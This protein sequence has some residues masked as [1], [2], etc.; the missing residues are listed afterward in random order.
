VSK[1]PVSKKPVE[2]TA[3]NLPSKRELTNAIMS[4]EQKVNMMYNSMAT[5]NRNLIFVLDELTEE[6]P[7]VSETD[8]SQEYLSVHVNHMFNNTYYDDKEENFVRLTPI[9]D[10]WTH[11]EDKGTY[12][13]DKEGEKTYIIDAKDELAAM[14]ALREK[15]RAAVTFEPTFSLKVVEGTSGE[16]LP[17]TEVI[18]IMEK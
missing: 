8:Y 15:L 9:V 14:K 18:E 16:L 4:L 2:N 3:V 10:G 12:T 11:E 5:V 7:T 13:F 1:K 17:L 6:T